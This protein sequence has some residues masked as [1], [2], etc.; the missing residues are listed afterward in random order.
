MSEHHNPRDTWA[1]S[2]KVFTLYTEYP[3]SQCI[4]DVLQGRL[5]G[6][7]EEVLL[8]RITGNEFDLLEE[9]FR[10]DPTPIVVAQDLEALSWKEK[11]II[12][13]HT[14]LADTVL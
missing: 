9:G 7:V 10:V 11:S 6:H 14:S 5:V 2:L 4:H 12:C 8:V 13:F 3:L 1:K